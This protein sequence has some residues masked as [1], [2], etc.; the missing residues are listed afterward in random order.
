MKPR[1]WDW[2]GIVSLLVVG[3]ATAVLGY[4]FVW[5]SRVLIGDGAGFFA[6]VGALVFLSFLL[7]A[8]EAAFSIAGKIKT[9]TD[10]LDEIILSSTNELAAADVAVAA[11]AI[12][13][14]AKV[15]RKQRAAYRKFRRLKRKERHLVGRGRIRV[16][17]ALSA[18]NVIINTVLVTF[19]P[20]F[21]LRTDGPRDPAIALLPPDK[22]LILVASALP[23]LY[24]GKIIPKMVGLQHAHGWGYNLYF[25]GNV[26]DRLIGWVP[27]GL[28]YGL[29]KLGFMKPDA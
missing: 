1:D 16:V 10:K 18:L 24:I 20:T 23:I 8:V 4:V 22:L 27:Q 9:V 7:T 28:H 25:I 19:L 17:G 29:V 6:L 2:D 13:K 21:L 3:A 11:A 15:R 12:A 5:K 26:A 14:S